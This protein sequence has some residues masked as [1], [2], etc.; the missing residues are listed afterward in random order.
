MICGALIAKKIS[1][2]KVT[3]LGALVFIGKNFTQYI[4]YYKWENNFMWKSGSYICEGSNILKSVSGFAIA[5]LFIDPNEESH[6][7]PDVKVLTGFLVGVAARPTL[8]VY[9]EVI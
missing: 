6:L 7:V 9:T 1:V 2:R 3:A 8:I 5:S 4:I